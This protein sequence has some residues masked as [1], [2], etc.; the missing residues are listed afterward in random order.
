MKINILPHTTLGKCSVGLFGCLI[1]FFVLLLI[2][3]ATG[4]TGGETFFSNLFLAIP[5]LLVVVSGIAAFFT[6]IINIIFMK[7]RALL[8]FLATAIGLLLIVFILGDLI[9]PEA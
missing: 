9:S 4:Q 2:M 3:G 6:G 5:G 1:I 7:E 8:V